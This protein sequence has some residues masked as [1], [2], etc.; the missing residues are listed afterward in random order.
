MF[1]VE[2]YRWEFE[3]QA[4]AGA[5]SA[6][7]SSPAGNVFAIVNAMLFRPDWM[8][9]DI[10][11]GARLVFEVNGVERAELRSERLLGPEDDANVCLLTGGCDVRCEGGDRLALRVEL[12]DGQTFPSSGLLRVVGLIRQAFLGE[13]PSTGAAGQA[14]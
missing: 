4:V 8:E 7:W 11:L 5:S 13:R 9:G 2:Y 1:N 6:A 10:L 12:T 14:G 3:V